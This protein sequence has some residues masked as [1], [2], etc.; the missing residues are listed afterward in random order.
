MSLLLTHAAQITGTLHR[1]GY[2]E[3]DE[4]DDHFRKMPILKRER[5]GVR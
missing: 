2:K 5:E 1:M 3:R 4:R